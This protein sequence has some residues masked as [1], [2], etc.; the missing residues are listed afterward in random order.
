MK[1]LCLCEQSPQ[2]AALIL[3]LEENFEVPLLL[4]PR[5]EYSSSTVSKRKKITLKKAINHLYFKF[6]K[7]LSNCE[8]M[9]QL[10]GTNRPETNPSLEV[11]RIDIRSDE[12]NS[13]AT[14]TLIENAAP[15]YLFV[16][17]APLLKKEI[18][19]IPRFGSINLHFGISPEY[20]G[21]HTLRYPYLEGNY[22]KLGATLHFID[23]GVDTGQALVQIYPEIRGSDSLEDVEAKIINLAQDALVKML[24]QA[25]RPHQR[26]LSIAKKGRM[27]RFQD[28][29]VIAD[30][31][32]AYRFLKNRILAAETILAQE[33]VIHFSEARTTAS[34]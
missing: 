12:I 30:L 6:L 9:D 5:Y 20:R 14:K 1:I 2:T 26:P 24:A 33:R 16:C 11:E 8:R 15:D 29:G 34:N 19:E 23:S 18:F 27:I 28:Y 10:F 3:A 13:T 4:T 32:C 17:G 31:R 7:L 21:H 22:E 25:P